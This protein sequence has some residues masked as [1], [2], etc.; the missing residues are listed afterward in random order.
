MSFFVPT[1]AGNKVTRIVPKDVNVEN[2]LLQKDNLA[3]REGSPFPPWTHSL[4]SSVNSYQFSLFGAFVQPGN[5]CPG[6]YR[7]TD[8]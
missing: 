2:N 3:L 4:G 8:H 7:F 5:T 1:V 6:N